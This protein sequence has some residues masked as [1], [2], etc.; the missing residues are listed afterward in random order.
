MR[1]VVVNRS[2][3]LHQRIVI[4]AHRCIA[5]KTYARNEKAEQTRIFHAAWVHRLNLH[6]F[7]AIVP[8]KVQSSPQLT[9]HRPGIPRYFLHL[10]DRSGQQRSFEFAAQVISERKR[11]KRVLQSASTSARGK[12]H[13]RRPETGIIDSTQRSQ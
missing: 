4:D 1:S 2:P 13:F 5:I 12:D 9:W 7:Q 8:V 6:N 3:P 10:T 11:T